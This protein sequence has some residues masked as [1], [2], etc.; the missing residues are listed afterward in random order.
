M[1]AKFLLL[2]S[3]LTFDSLLRFEVIDLVKVDVVER[4]KY[5]QRN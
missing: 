5:V 1:I 2:L 4:L 3:N